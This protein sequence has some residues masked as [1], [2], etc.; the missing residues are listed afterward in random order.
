MLDQTELDQFAKELVTRVRDPAIKQCDR[1]ANGNQR[2]ARGQFWRMFTENDSV[3]QG[4]LELIPDIVDEALFQLLNAIDNG[5]LPLALRRSDDS[6]VSLQELGQGEMAGW[7]TM[8]RDGWLERFSVERFH[9]HLS[10]MTD[11]S[12][13]GA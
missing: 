11:R 9:D 13:T 3:R 10:S 12:D 7:L 5:Q 8:G 1:L 2:S 4:V 6:S